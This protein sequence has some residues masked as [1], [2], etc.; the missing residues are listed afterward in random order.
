MTPL[1]KP[2][3]SHS[4]WFL[5]SREQ[6]AGWISLYWIKHPPAVRQDDLWLFGDH[7]VPVFRW[8]ATQIIATSTRFHS[9]SVL[10]PEQRLHLSLI[11]WEMT[12]LTIEPENGSWIYF[13]GQKQQIPRLQIFIQGWGLNWCLR[14]WRLPSMLQV[15]RFCVVVCV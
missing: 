5:L 1:E 9:G 11:C 10:S 13:M 7:P 6:L 8:R 14:T 3:M 4:D 2:V 15:F 12:L